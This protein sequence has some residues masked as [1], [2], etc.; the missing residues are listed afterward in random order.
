MIK[1]YKTM[2]YPS[3]V[4]EL[5]LA[6]EGETLVGLWIEGQKHF[7]AGLDLSAGGE[8]PVFERAKDWLD[9]YFAGERPD[10]SELPIAPVGTAFQRAVWRRLREIPYG[11][12]TT[13]GELA[14]GLASSARAVGSA[15]GRNPISIIVP[16]HRV[17]GADGG[18]TGY[19]GGV[20]RKQWLLKHE[21]AL[22]E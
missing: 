10:P 16:C 2:K 22:P 1:M 17:V 5:T 15:V 12:L 19:A 8:L 7:G 20:E 6:G 18:L 11:G 13:Y 3:P 4:G 21:G 14:K 9:R